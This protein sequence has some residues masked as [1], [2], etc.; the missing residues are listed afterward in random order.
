MITQEDVEK[1]LNW[2]VEHADKAAQARADRLHLEEF[3]KHLKADL[4]NECIALS[5]TDA[6]EASLGAQERYA[7][8]H[9]KYLVHLRG[10]LEAT[11]QDEKYRWLKEVAMTRVDV[12]RT[13]QSTERAFSVPRKT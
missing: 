11:K 4:M 10:L 2:L 3:T 6:K 1:A 8:S 12:W 9:E 7:L 5:A 13:I